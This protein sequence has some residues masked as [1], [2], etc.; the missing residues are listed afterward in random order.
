M[1]TRVDCEYIRGLLADFSEDNLLGRAA[2]RARDHVAACEACAD[3]LKTFEATADLVREKGLREPP[4]GLWNAVY[5]RITDPARAPSVARPAAGLRLR[6]RIGAAIAAL[7]LVILFG[8]SYV[9]RPQPPSVANAVAAEYVEGHAVGSRD[10]LFA[11]R[12]SLTSVAA[13]AEAEQ[14]ENGRL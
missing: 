13:L 11:D 5:N 2:R 9:R 8:L 6:L 4:V 7:S 10:G 12:F 1:E 14:R 3:E